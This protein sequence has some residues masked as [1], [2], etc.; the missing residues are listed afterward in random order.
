MEIESNGSGRPVSVHLILQGKEAWGKV[1]CRLSSPSISKRRLFFLGSA[2][3]S[4]M[5]MSS[6]SRFPIT[7]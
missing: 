7:E 6:E 4:C 2:H 1:L 3:R 5:L